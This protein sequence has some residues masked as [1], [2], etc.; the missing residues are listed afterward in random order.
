[1]KNVLTRLPDRRSVLGVYA[2]TV[3]L[4][5]GWTLL[6]SFWK[7][8]SWLYFLPVSD[9]LSVYA[10][11]FV[12]D[13][14][15]SLILLGATLLAGLLLPDRWWNARFTSQGVLWVLVLMGSAM[16][17]LYTNRSPDRWESFV[18]G[19]GIWWGTTFLLAVLLSFFTSHFAFIQRGLEDLA[20]RLVAFLYLYL[21][22]TVV[23]IFVVFVRVVF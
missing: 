7:V 10:Y 2:T 22:L 16:V 13:F 21:P 23:A 20:D 18:S 3:F 12:V 1:M 9:I 5:Y 15:E 6:A 4:V 11:S 19:Q 8:P 14:S 17:R